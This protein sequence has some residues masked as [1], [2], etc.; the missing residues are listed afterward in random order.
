MD[1]EAGND[2]V[3][4]NGAAAAG[5]SFTVNPNGQRVRFDR[6]NLVP[7]NLD[8]GTSERLDVNAGGG[9]DTIIGSDGLAQLISSS[10]DGQDGKDRITGTDGADELSGGTGNDLIRSR[11]RAADRVDCGSGL[12]LAIV[13]RRDRVSR[14]NIVLGGRA[15]VLVA[16]K[17]A[18]VAGGAAALRLRCVATQRCSVTVQLLRAGKTLGTK[19]LTIRSRASKRVSVKLNQRDRRLVTAASGRSLRV[20]VRIDARDAQGNG[21]RTTAPIQLTS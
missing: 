14:C 13:D 12:D 1:G 19:S 4:V 15:R 5:D 16:G 10:F 8:I 21:W 11:D 17:S 9:D 2:T 6:V 18:D 20:Q 3:E 7:F